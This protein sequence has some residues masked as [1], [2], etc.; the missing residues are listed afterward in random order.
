MDR[1]SFDSVLA[2]WESEIATYMRRKRPIILV[3]T[4][5][6]LREKMDTGEET[7]ITTDEGE[8]LA[9]QIGAEGFVECS[10]LMQ[11]GVKKVFEKIVLSALKYRKRKF[12]ILHR[13]FG[14]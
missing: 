13:I 3:A 8:E 5:K 4:Q 1:E 12:N 11:E 14:R 7:P 9:K 2:F 6:D 10:A